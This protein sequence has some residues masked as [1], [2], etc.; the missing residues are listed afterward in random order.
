M[1]YQ[2]VSPVQIFCQI[3]AKCYLKIAEV[4]FLPVALADTHFLKPKNI[5][6]LDS[7]HWK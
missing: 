2:V 4:S 5:L 1:D 3:Y 6:K 7:S